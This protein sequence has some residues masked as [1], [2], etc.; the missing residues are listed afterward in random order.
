[1]ANLRTMNNLVQV[2]RVISRDDLEGI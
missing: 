2:E 1:M